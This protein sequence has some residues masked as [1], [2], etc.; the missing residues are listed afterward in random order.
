M[1]P[2]ALGTYDCYVHLL[3]LAG[4]GGEKGWKVLWG[5]RVKK[6]RII[7]LMPPTIFFKI[8]SKWTLDILEWINYLRENVLR[9][10]VRVKGKGIMDVVRGGLRQRRPPCR[11]LVWWSLWRVD[12]LLRR[13]LMARQEANTI[14][15]MHCGNLVHSLHYLVSRFLSTLPFSGKKKKSVVCYVVLRCQRLS[16]TLQ[17][18]L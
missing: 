2:D 6:K 5:R 9:L 10:N 12:V 17:C 16:K 11:Y 18:L 4:E 1:F 7:K 13:T 14:G 8:N 3:Y 15:Y